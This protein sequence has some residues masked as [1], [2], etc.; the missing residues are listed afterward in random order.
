MDKRQGKGR[1]NKSNDEGIY[2]GEWLDDKFHGNGC[3]YW[4]SEKYYIGEFKEGKLEGVGIF[5]QESLLY[6]GKLINDIL[7]IPKVILST[8]L[9]VG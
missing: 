5:F 2:E 1:L 7:S 6:T 9:K 3:Y 8:I 4:S